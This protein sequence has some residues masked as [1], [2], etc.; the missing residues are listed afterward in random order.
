MGYTT[1]IIRLNNDN[2][3]ALKIAVLACLA[4]VALSDKAPPP[5]APPQYGPPP[6]YPAPAPY[7]PEPEYPAVPPKYEYTY[8]VADE[9]SGTNFEAA[10]NRDGYKTEGSYSVNLPDGRRQTVT[11]V[12]NGDGLEAVVTHEGE[13]QYPEYNPAPYPAPAP[14]YAPAQSYEPAPSPYD[15]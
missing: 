13:A 8:G 5:Y 10:E 14:V 15:A 3:M 2:D 1:I 4:V 7:H 11:Y 12:D 9:Y 6:S